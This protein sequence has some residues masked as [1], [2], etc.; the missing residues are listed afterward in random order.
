[1]EQMADAMAQLSL[2]LDPSSAK[3]AGQLL[4]SEYQYCILEK[5][6]PLKNADASKL[7]IQEYLYGMCLVMGHLMDT[8]GDWKSYFAHFK[9]VMKF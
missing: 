9:R 6:M 7:S 3:K 8:Q 4:R 5:G 2:S 1:M